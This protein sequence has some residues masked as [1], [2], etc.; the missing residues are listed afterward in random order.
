MIVLVREEFSDNYLQFYKDDSISNFY[1]DDF[2]VVIPVLNEEKAIGRVIEAVNKAGYHNILVVDGYSTDRTVS[3]ASDNGAIVIYQH[4]KG[5]TGAIRTAID[6]IVTPYFVVMDGDCTYDPKDI[7]NFYPKVLNHEQIIGSRT[8]GRKNIPL[9]NRFG[10]FV[11]NLFFNLLFGTNL[12]DV[13]SGMYAL[14]TD[15]AKTLSLN[16]GGFD[17]EVEIAAQT[18]KNGRITQVP[19]NY[20]ERV[21]Q[22]KLRPLRHGLQ[23]LTTVWKLSIYYSLR[24]HNNL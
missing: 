23:I 19:I 1:K 12:V 24:A 18:A 21:G 8:L 5:K 16:T 11:I 4:G 22:Q 9:L 2:S 17:V 7:R 10:N 20:Y 14:R 3:V 6:H 13:C 15:Y